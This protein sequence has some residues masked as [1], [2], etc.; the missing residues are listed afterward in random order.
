MRMRSD[1]RLDLRGAG[2]HELH[3][4]AALDE[5]GQSRQ[6]KIEPFVRLGVAGPQDRRARAP[7]LVDG[8]GPPA[9]RNA[10]G[11]DVDLIGRCVQQIRK[12]VARRLRYRDEPVRDPRRAAQQSARVPAADGRGQQPAGARQLVGVAEMD[13]VVDR[14]DE[15]NVESDRHDVVGGVKDGRS[16]LARLRREF[17]DRQRSVAGSTRPER[18]DVGVAIERTVGP[19]GEQAK[20]PVGPQWR[21]GI[22]ELEDIRA[23]PVVAQLRGVDRDLHGSAGPGFRSAERSIRSTSRASAFPRRALRP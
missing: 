12:V 16:C 10:V 4:V 7:L 1:E 6:Q 13:A 14:R 23:D 22:D 8:S 15:G 5:L 19:V 2:E 18:A 9:R 3:V 11:H 17:P 20:L 21:R